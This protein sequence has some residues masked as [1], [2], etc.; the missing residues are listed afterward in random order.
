MKTFIV[1]LIKSIYVLFIIGSLLYLS[2]CSAVPE[3]LPDATPGLSVTPSTLAP[4]IPSSTVQALQEPATLAP[5]SPTPLITP[6]TP[7]ELPLNEFMGS[8]AYLDV[9]YQVDLGPR[10]PGSDAH[11]ALRSWVFK[12]L[13]QAGWNV[14]E[15]KTTYA[16]QPVF[17]IVAKNN[18]DID[19]S[20]PWLII[21]AHYDSR[22]YADHDPDVNK[23]NLPVPGANDGASGV[24]VLLELARTLPK[25]LDQQVWLVFFDA[26][27]NGRIP[28]WDWILGSRAFAESLS[29]K[30]DAVVIVDMVGDKD[31]NLHFEKNSDHQLRQE[32]WDVAEELGYADYFIP[33][34]KYRILDDHIPFI[35][36]GIPSVDIIDFDYEYWHTVADTADK[37]S[38]ESLE[39]VGRTVWTWLQTYKKGN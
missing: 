12:E 7:T 28:G 24:A 6:S 19:P 4:V 23:R 35:E 36:I 38:E 33:T 5:P 27:D 20:K 2:S 21:G 18:T 10:L 17:N 22:F 26:E 9:I 25:N 16:G 39:I 29:E 8:R 13:E 34:E 14:E 3:I 1:Y 31:L 37:V 11:L 30:P 15:Q 32:I